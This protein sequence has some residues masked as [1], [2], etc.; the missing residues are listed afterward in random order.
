MA[1]SSSVFAVPL[2]PSIDL[3]ICIVNLS[4]RDLLRGCLRSIY[5]QD[6]GAAVEVIVV[7]NCS[8]DG[9]REMVRD[10][11]PAARLITL[12]FI[13]GFAANNNVAIRQ[14][15]GRHVMLLNND[16]EVMPGALRAHVSY[17]DA[18]PEVGGT[19]G[20][21]HQPDGRV[22]RGCARLLPRL[23]SELY[24]LL[25]LSARWPEHPRYGRAF[26]GGWDY[27]S[28]RRIE[29]PLEANMALR[30][31]VI[32]QVGLLDERF[33]IVFGE[34]PDWLRRVKDAGWPVMFLPEADVLHYGGQSWG[35]IRKKALYHLRENEYRYYRKHDGW[36]AAQAFRLMVLATQLVMLG[37]Y[38]VSAPFKRRPLE[39]L[40]GGA[41][42]AWIGLRWSIGLLPA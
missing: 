14:C 19:G 22:Q 25:H 18:H 30:R 6:Q 17:L 40:R 34:G 33:E 26:F 20:R 7:D 23:E 13:Q 36:G 42:E 9:S 32:E 24:D 16:T 41:A 35:R 37:V 1:D 10:E 3:S 11:F 8:A 2:D 21:V 15:H 27:S 31:E 4:S 39:Y 38:V 12:D 5:G 28:V 29:L